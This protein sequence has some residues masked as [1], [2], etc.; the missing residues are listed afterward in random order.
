MT[1]GSE[2]ATHECDGEEN[3][4]ERGH[5]RPDQERNTTGSQGS[6]EAALAAVPLSGAMAKWRDAAGEVT[7]ARFRIYLLPP[8]ARNVS[9]TGSVAKRRAYFLAG[10]QGRWTVKVVPWSSD[11]STSMRPS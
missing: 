9:P 10:V 1:G 4:G 2:F 11:D 5:E 8:G 7:P 6:C 3:R